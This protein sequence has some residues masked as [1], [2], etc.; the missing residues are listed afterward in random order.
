TITRYNCSEIITVISASSRRALIKC[1]V[2]RGGC[3]D[4]LAGWHFHI[5][6][7]MVDMRVAYQAVTGHK[8]PVD[9]I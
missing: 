2:E 7:N 4:A 9:Q 5:R 3:L 6:G 1:C 8:R